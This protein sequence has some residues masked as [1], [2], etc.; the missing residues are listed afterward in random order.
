MVSLAERTIRN[1]SLEENLP[2]ADALIC[3]IEHLYDFLGKNYGPAIRTEREIPFREIRKGRTCVGSIDFVWYTSDR[4]CVLVDYKN[5]SRASAAVIDRDSE[6]YIGHYIPQQK[7]YKDALER[8]GFN[9]MACLL[10]LSLQE[11]VI[12]IEL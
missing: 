2:D 10:H 4:D 9:V 1:F 6:E 5:L 11:K 3:S 7:A 8:T 12:Q